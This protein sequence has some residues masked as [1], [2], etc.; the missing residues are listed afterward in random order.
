MNPSQNPFVKQNP[1]MSDFIQKTI[2]TERG[3]YPPNR[4]GRR[5]AI[6]SIRR[7]FL[8]RGITY[9]TDGSKIKN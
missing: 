2:M 7:I 3:K 8:L 6:R 1:E 5:A 9:D 4:Q